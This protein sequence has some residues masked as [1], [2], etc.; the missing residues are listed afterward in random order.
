MKS[1][2]LQ[3][4]LMRQIEETKQFLAT[5]WYNAIQEL[6]MR[7]VKKHL[8]QAK[9][10]K[11]KSKKFF[12]LLAITMENNLQDVCERS[13]VA[14]T[15]YICQMEVTI[16]LQCYHNRIIINLKSPLSESPSDLQVEH[17]PGRIRDSGLHPDVY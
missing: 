6:I 16:V 2:S 15:D 17:W 3:A 1:L 13:L 11:I 7:K 8:F 10:S 14:Y 9:I 4:I 5:T 12:R